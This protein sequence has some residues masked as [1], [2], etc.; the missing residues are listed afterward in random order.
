MYILLLITPGDF[1]GLISPHL[2]GCFSLLVE[3]L[4]QG[5]DELSVVLGGEL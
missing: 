3:Q 1:F 4:L 2:S 5:L